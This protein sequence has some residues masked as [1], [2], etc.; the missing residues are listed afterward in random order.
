[1]NYTTNDLMVA[2]LFCLCVIAIVAGIH[3]NKHR[4]ILI[5]DEDIVSSTVQ[6]KARWTLDEW[7]TSK[8]LDAGFDIGLHEAKIVLGIIVIVVGIIVWFLTGNILI[9]LATGVVGVPAAFNAIAGRARIKH[10]HLLEEQFGHMLI[11]LAAQLEAGSTVGGAFTYARDASPEPIRSILKRIVDEM[12]IGGSSLDEALRDVAKY[13]RIEDWDAF[14]AACSI[15][16]RAG[17]G[18]LPTILTNL[19][20]AINERIIMRSH[21]RSLLMEAA[22]SRYVLVALPPLVFLYQ[23]VADKSSFATLTRSSTGIIMLVIAFGLWVVGNFIIGK[24]IK[25]I[26]VGV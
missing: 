13:I 1:M 3:R 21:A 6:K 5:S 17:G 12:S 16:S 2:L 8:M 23:M 11:A 24:M 9:G 18:E 15:G 7:L 26:E 19:A 22:M 25:K 10:N 14:I 4:G 20:Q